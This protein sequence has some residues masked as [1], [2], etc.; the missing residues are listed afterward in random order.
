MV[1][2]KS[3][4]VWRKFSCGFHFLVH[5][6][7]HSMNSAQWEKLLLTVTPNLDKINLND[8]V[9]EKVLLYGDR[10]LNPSQNKIILDSTLNFVQETG[11]FSNEPPRPFVRYIFSF[12]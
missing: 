9:L 11:R 3:E 2:G 4:Y 1:V 10:N 8:S 7:D 12:H 5:A 6:N